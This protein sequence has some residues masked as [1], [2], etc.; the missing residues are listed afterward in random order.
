MMKGLGA[1][2]LLVAAGLAVAPVAMTADADA[3][4][5]LRL[6]HYA[7]TASTTH[8]AAEF[9]AEEV[10]R[11]S[12][13]EI[14][15]TIHPAH[16]LGDDP[17]Q[18]RGVRLGTIDMAVIGNTFFTGM[19]PELNA[20][21]LPYLFTSPDH[22]YRVLD[23]EI[24]DDLH[25]LFKDNGMQVLGNWEIGFRNIT[26][27][28]RPIET[29]DDVA[30]LSI[31]TTPNPAHVT[32]FETLGANPTPMSF[33]EVYLA[34]ETGAVDG[35]ENP[36][37]LI[38]AMRFHE[39]QQYLSLTRHAYTAAFLVMNDGRFSSLTDEQQAMLLEVGQLAGQMERDLIAEREAA[40]LQAMQDEGLIV[41]EEPDREAFREAVMEATRA[42]YVDEFGSDLLDRI[43]AA[44]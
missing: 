28:E 25:Q 20:L 5:T 19:A 18:V 37:V 8:A 13:G 27:S 41:I 36:V 42:A 21:D 31:R 10:A 2:S 16:E 7:S 38:H 39:V 26:N 44:R 14:T 11:R 30:G 23:G 24:G 4:T 34:L 35:Q 32:A 12:N 40:S 15:V 6:A 22:A 29:P 17:T 3:E 1:K 9:F 43:D 33:S